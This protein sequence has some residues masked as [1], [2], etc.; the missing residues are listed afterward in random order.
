MRY[1]ENIFFHMTQEE[2][3]KRRQEMEAEIAANEAADRAAR[4]K[5]VCTIVLIFLV[6]FTAIGCYLAFRPHPEPE[7]YYKDG[8]IDYVAQADKLRR[9]GKFKN[10]EA[11]RGGY[12]IVSDG[13]KFGIVDVKGNV[14]CPIEFDAIESN[15]NEHYPG[16]ALVRIGEKYGLVDT[17]GKTVVGVDY[18]EIGPMNGG[19]MEVVLD[20]ESFYIDGQGNRVK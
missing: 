17:Q 14:V 5:Q 3:E 2:Q 12:A 1:R 16:L 8:D 19:T 15:Y 6:V 20:G 4:R 9:S 18:D 11:F 10:V 13:K 7:V